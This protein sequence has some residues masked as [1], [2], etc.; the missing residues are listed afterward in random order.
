[1]VKLKV[2]DQKSHHFVIEADEPVT[3]EFNMVKKTIPL[4]SV[5]RRGFEE[6]ILGAYDGTL[7]RNTDWEVGT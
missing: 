1:M 3:I 2:Y 5:Y 6:E 4:V 7:N